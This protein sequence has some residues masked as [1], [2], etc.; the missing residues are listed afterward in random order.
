MRATLATS[1]K[2]GRPALCAGRHVCTDG[3][4]FEL[5]IPLPV[6][7]FSRPVPSTTR[8]PILNCNGYRLPVAGD[9]EKLIGLGPK[10][11]RGELTLPAGASVRPAPLS[12]P[13]Y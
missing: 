2:R 3:V 7:R 6:C 4:R 10:V 12:P 8:P 5:T 1:R 9:R 11:R 13:H